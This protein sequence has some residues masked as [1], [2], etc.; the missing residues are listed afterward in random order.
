MKKLSLLV[1]CFT[2][3][4]C[5][6]LQSNDP[7]SIFFD[8]P[9]GSTLSLNKNLPI[10]ESDTHAIIQYGKV[11]NVND[12]YDYDVNCRL[13]FNKFGPRTI[14][15]E[16]FK[17]TRTE[18]GRNAISVGIIFRFWTALYLSSDKGTDIIKMVC[19]AYDGVAGRNF[20]VADM[21]DTLGDYLTINFAGEKPAK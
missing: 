21:Q 2:L 4:A 17:I 12:R 20:P 7:H 11:T 10:D 14:E 15:P 16:V 5:A 1:T 19:Q 9:E 8:I 13:D 6:S 18:D 3:G